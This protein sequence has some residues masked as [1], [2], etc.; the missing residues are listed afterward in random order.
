MPFGEGN[1]GEMA[2]ATIKAH[3]IVLF[4]ENTGEFYETHKRMAR[5]GAS[6]QKWFEHV[7]GPVMRLY[8]RQVEHARAWPS[9]RFD[10]AGELKAYYE[11]HI[12]D[13]DVS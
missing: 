2:M 11:R 7:S 1:I 13:G 12:Q 9:D 10:A 3:E 4:A 6:K 5:E 8:C